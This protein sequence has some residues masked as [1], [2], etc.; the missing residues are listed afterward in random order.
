MRN[1]SPRGLV[2][3]LVLAATLPMLALFGAGSPIAA[4]SSTLVTMPPPTAARTSTLQ[5]FQETGTPVLARQATP[6][7]QLNPTS[8]AVSTPVPV[9]APTV[10]A[11]SRLILA[12][13]AVV[14]VGGM[15]VGLIGMRRSR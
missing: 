5:P 12:L 13:G 4:A 10:A 15:L 6:A 3:C 8:G 9:A 7:P 2:A 14:V 11:R 1:V